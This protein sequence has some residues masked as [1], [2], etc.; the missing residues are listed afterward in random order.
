MA[1]TLKAPALRLLG[2]AA[3]I[4]IA[5]SAAYG[6]GVFRMSTLDRLEKVR[7]PHP[8]RSMTRGFYRAFGRGTG[9]RVG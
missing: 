7:M 4:A 1:V 9:E 8:L 3:V 2:C 5:V 6:I